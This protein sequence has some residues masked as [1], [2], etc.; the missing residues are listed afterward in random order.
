MAK[1]IEIATRVQDLYYQN[2]TPND[3][4]L[5]IEDFKFWVA[6]TY[7]TLL[8]TA[9]Q[10]ERKSNKQM[11]GF[12]NIDIP[13][14]WLYQEVLKIEFN[15]E[16]NRFFAKT[17]YPMYFFS[18]DGATN[19]LQGV[20][21]AGGP[22]CVYRKMSLNER[23]FRQILPPTSS[24]LF[25]VENSREIVFWEAKEGA[26]IET[27]YIPAVVGSENDCFISDN[28]IKPLTDGT[29]ELLFKS[30]SGNF[31]QKANDQNPNTPVP[32]GDPA[33]PHQ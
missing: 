29:L 13:A 20:H 22:H 10:I 6:S 27:Q 21:S 5:D 3:A 32:Q 9:F 2:Y 17:K 16:R 1:L 7:N 24:I 14:Q 8:D 31:I 26:M 30:K 18:W 19:S 4:Y 28:L 15:K 33:L 25:Y 23:K 12:S 11:D